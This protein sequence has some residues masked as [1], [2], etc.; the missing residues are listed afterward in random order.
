MR[1]PAITRFPPTF[2]RRIILLFFVVLALGLVGMLILK[3]A[4]PSLSTIGSLFAAQSTIIRDQNGLELYRIHGD[5]DRTD[6]PLTNIPLSLQQAT[7]AIEDE[8]FY[9][10]GCFDTRAF[11]RAILQNVVGGWKS[12]G[13]STITQQFAKQAFVGTQKTILRKIRQVLLSCKLERRYSKD[14][15]LE[16]YLNRIPYGHGVSGVEQASLLYFAKSA[17]GLTLAESA[18]LAALPQRPSYF[19]PYGSHRRTTLSKEILSHITDGKITEMNDIPSSA[20]TLGLLGDTFGTGSTTLYVGGRTDQVLRNMRELGFITEEEEQRALEELQGLTFSRMREDIRAPHFVLWIEQQLRES[21]GEELITQGGLNI[22]TTLDWELQQRAESAIRAY[23][24]FNRDV[25]AAHNI[26]LVALE[27]S[28]GNVLAYVGNTDYSDDEHSGKVDMVRAPRQPGSSFKPFVYATAF[29]KGYSPASI[30]EDVDTPLGDDRPQ[31]YDGTTWGPITMRRALGASRN[32]PAAKMYF[33]AGGEGAILNL[34]EDLGIPS[35][36]ERQHA[37]TEERGSAYEYGWP[38]ALGAGEVPLLEMTTGYLSLARGGNVIAPRSILKIEDRNGN[39][40]FEAEPM[41]EG[42]DVLDPRIAYQITSILSDVSVRPNAFWQSQLSVPGIETA[43]KTGTSAKCLKRGSPPEGKEHALGACIERRSDNTWTIGYTPSIVVGVWAGNAD[44][45][46]L[47]LQADG[48]TTASR[49]WHDFMTAASRL[50]PGKPLFEEPSG[51][52]R[53]QVSLLSG[54]PPSPCTPERLR[55]T[56]IFLEERI[57]KSFDDRCTLLEVDRVTGLLASPSCPVSARETRAFLSPAPLAEGSLTGWEESYALWLEQEQEKWMQVEE[58]K[59]NGKD[60]PPSS[61][62]LLPLPLPPT[63]VCDT[64]LTPGRL[65]QP[66]VRFLSPENGGVAAFPSF[67]PKIAHTVGSSVREI[68]Y[69]VNGQNVGIAT[70]APFTF[71]VAL[72]HVA[73]EGATISL[74]A[75]LV[76]EYYNEAVASI[77]VRLEKDKS[78]PTV[79]LLLPREGTTFTTSNT[80]TIEAQAEDE[81]GV[82]RVQFFLDEQL[83]TTR[84]AGPYRLE[85]PLTDLTPGAH[86]VEARAEDG[87]GNIGVDAVRIEVVAQ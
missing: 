8:R 82:D 38:L 20:I 77:R 69:E 41:Q 16:L 80:L 48:L 5:E 30:I 49:I 63:E 56:D 83:L 19:S 46:S 52:V 71:P 36:R 60:V 43:A 84:R 13:G 29:E 59:R 67:T 31:N 55:G 74:K 81:G 73:K 47:S 25:Y 61:G 75:T 45:S 17:S 37:L 65:E 2:K 22:R 12:Q 14:E 51:I 32:I 27:K 18:I 86:T 39:L 35:L 7:I 72:Q 3:L 28:T 79:R 6:V 11:L 50:R 54:T 40:L 87:A 42:E 66:T 53:V 1:I 85:Y 57:P 70:E 23:A 21:F 34:A 58:W 15:I 62:S 76:D 78:I 68:R 10:R 64:A 9:E 26:S 4:L 44:G 33:L 24:E